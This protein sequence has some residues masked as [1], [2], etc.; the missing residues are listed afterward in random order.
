M[1]GLERITSAGAI[2]FGVLPDDE[3]TLSVERRGNVTQRRHRDV[4]GFAGR[5]TATIE[6][7][8]DL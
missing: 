2:A 7:G 1:N 8:V 6:A 5:G 3:A 4:Q